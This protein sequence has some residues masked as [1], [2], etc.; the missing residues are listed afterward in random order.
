MNFT[1]LHSIRI[2]LRADGSM[3]RRS[4]MAVVVRAAV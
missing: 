1:V 3:S 4:V 2:A